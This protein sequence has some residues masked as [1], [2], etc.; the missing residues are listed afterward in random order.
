MEPSGT[1]GANLKYNIMSFPVTVGLRYRI[2][3]GRDDAEKERQELMQ[4]G[5]NF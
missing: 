2:K 5:M 1:T 4:V 3:G